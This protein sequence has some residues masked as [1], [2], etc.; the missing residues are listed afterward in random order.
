MDE[1]KKGRRPRREL[2]VVGNVHPSPEIAPWERDA[3]A[4]LLAKPSASAT[5]P[6]GEES[7]DGG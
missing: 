5:P 2:A 7:R 1:R 3:L 6:G 4:L